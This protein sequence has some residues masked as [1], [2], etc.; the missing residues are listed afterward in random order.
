VTAEEDRVLQL[1]CEAWRKFLE[2]PEGRLADEDEFRHA[3]Y[4][5]QTIILARVG[6]RT[7]E[8]D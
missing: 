2:L 8:V 1:L 7:P 5:A 4:A 3:I 6:H